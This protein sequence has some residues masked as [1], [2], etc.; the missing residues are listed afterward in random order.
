MPQPPISFSGVHCSNRAEKRGQ[1]LQAL[2]LA[3]SHILV[4]S[5]PRK[6]SGRGGAQPIR[7]RVR[8]TSFRQALR[9]RGGREGWYFCTPE[10]TSRAGYPG[11]NFQGYQPFSYPHWGT[12][13]GAAA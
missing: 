11:L 1:R 5:S 7:L 3:A 2:H 8:F 10:D 9:P 13:Q 12:T 6:P 4:M